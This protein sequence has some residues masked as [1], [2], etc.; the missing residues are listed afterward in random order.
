MPIF[1]VKLEF[2]SS[3]DEST[4]LGVLR[5][6]SHGLERL[7]VAK[8]SS[9]QGFTYDEFNLRPTGYAVKEHRLEGDEVI[10]GVTMHTTAV[11]R[12]VSMQFL[13]E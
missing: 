6:N 9:N 10:V 1:L 2:I 11:G 5:T 8:L 7:G 4:V 13:I 3:E 12:L